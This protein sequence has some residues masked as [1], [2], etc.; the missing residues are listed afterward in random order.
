M[1]YTINVADV[2][3]R[4]LENAPMN[5]VATVTVEF[6]NILKISGISIKERKNG[7]LYVEMPWLANVSARSIIN[8]KSKYFV[9]PSNTDF[10]KELYS[11]IIKTYVMGDMEYHSSVDEP[12]QT[13]KR[14]RTQNSRND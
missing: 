13:R 10:A 6:D 3:N 12:E 14:K 4:E 2:N 5:L 8:A 1:V 9:T 11:N 7:I